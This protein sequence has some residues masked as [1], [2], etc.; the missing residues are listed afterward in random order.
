MPFYDGLTLEEIGGRGVRWQEREAAAALA[1]V[2][3]P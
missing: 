2:P 3:L 1:P